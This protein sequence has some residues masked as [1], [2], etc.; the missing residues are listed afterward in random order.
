[1]PKSQTYG[2]LSRKL[3]Q[4]LI[5]RTILMQYLSHGSRRYKPFSG[6]VNLCYLGLWTHP[7]SL[8]CKCVIAFSLTLV[9]VF[10]VP[11]WRLL[12]DCNWDRAVNQLLTYT[13]FST[14]IGIGYYSSYS[15][16]RDHYCASLRFVLF[17]GVYKRPRRN[18]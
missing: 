12:A 8:V 16:K 9:N 3:F 10:W 11:T 18:R 4:N 17:M 7:L 5:Y 15:G 6:S 2:W 14:I 13:K 1:M